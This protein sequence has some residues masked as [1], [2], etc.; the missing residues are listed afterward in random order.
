MVG[1]ILLMFLAGL[2]LFCLSIGAGLFEAQ[3][4]R[5]VHLMWT[6]ARSASRGASSPPSL[7]R[8]HCCSSP[9]ASPLSTNVPPRRPILRVPRDCAHHPLRSSSLVFNSV[10]SSVL[11]TSVLSPPTKC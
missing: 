11:T 7:S 10:S 4:S 8:H 2:E 6:Q 3:V 9:L 5:E 1:C